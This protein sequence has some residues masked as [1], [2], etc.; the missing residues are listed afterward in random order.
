MLV[1]KR[2]LHVWY[3]GTIV[4]SLDD[5]MALVHVQGDSIEKD[6]WMAMTALLPQEC[7]VAPPPRG[8]F[9]QRNDL[10]YVY[11]A[12]ASCAPTLREHGLLLVGTVIERIPQH[13]AAL[14]DVLLPGPDN[15]RRCQLGLGFLGPIL[16]DAF[17]AMRERLAQLPS[18]PT[19]DATQHTV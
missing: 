7:I 14:L 5:D 6:V 1:L 11:V 9:A 12:D 10:V 18:H 17:Q 19:P 3:L 16:P 4:E 15:M 8:W 13:D 2:W